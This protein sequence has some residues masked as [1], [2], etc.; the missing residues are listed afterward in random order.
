MSESQ[1]YATQGY[2]GNSGQ[3]DLQGIFG[4]VFGKALGGL[5]GKHLGGSTGQ[6]AGSWAGGALG[7]LIPFEAGPTDAP[8]SDLE[9]QGFW[10]VVKKIGQ[11]A[12][13][14]VQAGH[15]LGLFQADQPTDAPP[16][17]LEMQ[18]F[19]NVV[20]KIGQVASK[21]VQAGHNL[22][23]FQ[24]DQPTAGSYSN[25]QMLGLLQQAL[26]ALQALTQQQ[27]MA[28]RSQ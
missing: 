11:V 13:K 14:G 23:L 16:S 26:P 6:K 21:G 24:A 2:G 9:M 17:D 12:S 3:L 27:Q 1:Q 19:W 7:T 10:S 8:P 28:G 18:G 25:E 20:K 5:V 15:N 4:A 22:G